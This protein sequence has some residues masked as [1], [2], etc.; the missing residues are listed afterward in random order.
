MFG[1]KK[2]TVT[3]QTHL[4]Q[5][6]AFVCGACG[7]KANRKYKTCPRCGRGV[8]K[9]KRIPAGSMKCRNLTISLNKTERNTYRHLPLFV[10]QNSTL[11]T[12]FQEDIV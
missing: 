1:K 2:T 9:V 7:Y 12:L 11:N 8:K 3:R 5:R 10:A 4:F 6:D